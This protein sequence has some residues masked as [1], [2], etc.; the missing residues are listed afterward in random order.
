MS[1]KAKPPEEGE[2]QSSTT[3]ATIVN[4]LVGWSRVPCRAAG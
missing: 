4:L 3:R 1:G 2:N